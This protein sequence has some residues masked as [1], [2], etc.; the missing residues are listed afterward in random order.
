MC[1]RGRR[2]RRGERPLL[3]GPTVGKIPPVLREASLFLQAEDVLVEV[4]GRIRDGDWEIELPAFLDA[5]PAPET[6]R[7]LVAR[8][9][10]ADAAVPAL[11]AGQPAREGGGNGLGNVLGNDLGD[12]PQDAVRLA[13]AAAAA[14][15]R[16]VTDPATTVPAGPDGAAVGV[17]EFLARAAVARSFAAHD[18]AMSRVAGL[19]ADRGAGQG[20]VGGHVAGGGPVAR[21]ARVR[22][23][24]AVAGR[25]LVARPLPALRRPRPAPAGALSGV[26]AS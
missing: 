21:A 4:L 25:R 17:A 24:A 22:R 11:L 14:A 15:V 10:R 1:R 18:V 5:G 6:M 8:I 9:V 3:T 13:S 16:D 23:A 7:T 12:E 2:R 19:P 20:A 26:T